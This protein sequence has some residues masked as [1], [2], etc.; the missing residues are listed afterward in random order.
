MTMLDNAY[1]FGPVCAGAQDDNDDNLAG[2][3]MYDNVIHGEISE[4][5]DRP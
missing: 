5:S 4:I 3:Y 2:V 1:G